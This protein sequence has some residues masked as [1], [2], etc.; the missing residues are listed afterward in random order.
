MSLRTANTFL[1]AYR[2]GANIVIIII[3]IIIIVVTLPV[4]RVFARQAHRA[5]SIH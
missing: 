5:Q 1:R 3:I 4:R 2:A